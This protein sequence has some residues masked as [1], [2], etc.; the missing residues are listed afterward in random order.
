MQPMD[1]EAKR[2]RVSVGSLLRACRLRAGVTL[3]DAAETLNIR[4]PYLHAI[5]EGRYGDLPGPAYAL[6]FVRGYAEYLGL[7][8]N[9]VTRRFQAETA[10]TERAKTKEPGA[11]RPGT[12]AMLHFPLAASETASPKS[13]VLLVGAMI[14]L[15]AYGGWY[16]L[17]AGNGL[18]PNLVAPLPARLAALLPDARVVPDPPSPETLP[19]IPKRTPVDRAPAEPDV[20]EGRQSDSPATASEEQPALERPATAERVPSEAVVSQAEPA[21]APALPSADPAG[22]DP[23]SA[24]PV[25]TA[26][27]PRVVLQAS[28]ESW[29]EIRDRFNKRVLSRLMAVGD[30]LEVPDQA[31]LRL[32]VGNAGGIVIT[33][34]GQAVPPLGGPGVVL[35]NVSL[36]A[37]RL[38]H[39][40]G[41]AN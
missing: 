25:A 18:P 36:E 39:A 28:Q 24:D 13:G 4:R 3:A 15:V 29:V 23:V 37:A 35:R 30:R 9:E 33:V 38:Q 8:G 10:G 26:D 1:G 16:A 11:K 20:T 27:R 17:T 22:A 31:G 41:G 19:P 32:T 5:E 12:K 21:P 40:D 7:D 34:D 2:E 14:A 6:G